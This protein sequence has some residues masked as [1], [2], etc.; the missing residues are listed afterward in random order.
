MFHKLDAC[1][2]QAILS[3]GAV[4]GFEIG[5]GF[6]AAA[7]SGSENND[8]FYMC[9]GQIKKETQPFRRYSGRSQRR[10]R[11]RVPRSR[12]ANAFHCQKTAYC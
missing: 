11:N 1:L 2:A 4:K 10:F 9:N 6:H 7:L 5:E 3:I 8:S 12:K